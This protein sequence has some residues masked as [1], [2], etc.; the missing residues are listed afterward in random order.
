MLKTNEPSSTNPR[1]KTVK[2]SSR[3]TIKKTN[4]VLQE[5]RKQI[6][7]EEQN[8]MDCLKEIHRIQIKSVEKLNTNLGIRKEA[9]IL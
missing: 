6:Q 2:I 9:G 5:H 8:N 7:E 1:G 4:I 3:N